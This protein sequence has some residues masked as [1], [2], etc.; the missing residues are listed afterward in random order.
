VSEHVREAS[1]KGGHDPNT[2][3]SLTGTKKKLII[4][5]D[6]FGFLSFGFPTQQEELVT[7]GIRNVC[8]SSSSRLLIQSSVLVIYMTPDT[9]INSKLQSLD[10]LNA[11]FKCPKELQIKGLPFCTEDTGY[12]VDAT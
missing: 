7:T 4:N 2:S 12:C 5:N 9:L 11:H 3:R 6:I 1:I 10:S 8:L